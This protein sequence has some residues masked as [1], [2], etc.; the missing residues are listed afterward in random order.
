MYSETQTFENI[1]NRMLQRIPDSI[2]KREGSIIWDALAPAA[3]EIESM[4]IALDEY[5]KQ[6][7]A[8]TADREFLKMRALERGLEPIPSTPSVLK[9]QFNVPVNE[10]IRFKTLSGVQFKTTK[11][12]DEVQ[13]IYELECEENGI[14]GNISDDKLVQIDYV[15]DL[16]NITI[17]GIAINGREEE[18]TETFRKRYLNSFKDLAYGG[19]IADYK[20]KT[21]KIDGVGAVKVTPVWNGGG[22]VKVTILS[23]VYGKAPKET[24][25]KVQNTLDPSQDYN[26]LGLAPIGHVVTVDTVDEV[27][28]K[29]KFKAVYLEHSSFEYNVD[30]FKE[31][32]NNYLHELCKKWEDNI[33]VIR[34]AQLIS[35]LLQITNIEDITD[36]TINNN[37]SN[38][39]LREFEIPKLLSVEEVQ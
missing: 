26:G 3:L 28:I 27:D 37:S 39:K 4:Y 12:L 23:S 2:D 32:I 21:L 25:T 7:M 30:K 31:V 36:L 19:N 33:V 8:L 14:I 13:H 20:E 16:Q 29:I 17:L 38:V 1:I 35:R 5:I 24:I 11:C 6:S 22:T 15:R 18:P 34:P 9:V 10:G